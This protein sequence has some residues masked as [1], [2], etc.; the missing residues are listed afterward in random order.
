M[1]GIITKAALIYCLRRPRFYNILAST[2]HVIFL[3]TPHHGFGDGEFQAIFGQAPTSEAA[4]R[5]RVW[6][7]SLIELSSTFGNISSQSRI[8]FTTAQSTEPSATPEG[9]IIPVLRHGLT[10]LDATS[11]ETVLHPFEASHLSICKF[12]TKED[13][14][15]ALL[16][17]EILAHIKLYQLGLT[18]TSSGVA[19]QP[20]PPTEV[21]LLGNLTRTA[22]DIKR[23]LQRVD[24]TL[25]SRELRYNHEEI[26]RQRDQKKSELAALL[27]WLWPIPEAERSS[28]AMWEQALEEHANAIDNTCEWL[29]HQPS[30][31]AWAASGLSQMAF[32]HGIPASGKSTLLA[33]LIAQTQRTV[34]PLAYWFCDSQSHST[35]MAIRAMSYQLLRQADDDTAINLL[36]P[37]KNKLAGGIG[38]AS[39]AAEILKQ[40]L[41]SMPS[42][43]LV[44]DALD[45]AEAATAEKNHPQL[46]LE[47]L[48]SVVRDIPL[49]VKMFCSSRNIP[50]ILNAMESMGSAI[51]DLNLTDDLIQDD[52]D[53]V[54]AHHV[55][56]SG[57]G[58]RLKTDTV[59]DF[60]MHRLREASRGVFL[61]AIIMIEDLC[62]K[63]RVRDI[64]EFF[65][66]FP[67]KSKI[68]D[69]YLS[70]VGRVD[71]TRLGI[72]ESDEGDV[73]GFCMAQKLLT[74]LLWSRSPLTLEQLQEAL[75][76]DGA[77]F[78]DLEGDI[79]LALGCLVKSESGTI[80]ISHPSIRRFL[81]HSKVFRES[82]WYE[83]LIQPDP[84]HYL[85]TASLDYMIQCRISIAQTIPYL[86]SRDSSALYAQHPFLAYASVSWLFHWQEAESGEGFARAMWTLIHEDNCKNFLRWQVATAYFLSG[87][88]FYSLVCILQSLLIRRRDFTEKGTPAWSQLVE[89]ELCL[90]R[91]KQF[92]LVWGSTIDR[93]PMDVMSVSQLMENPN[94]PIGETPV[95]RTLLLSE[96]SCSEEKPRPLLDRQRVDY[97][98]DRFILSPTDMFLWRSLMPC[99]SHY[100]RTGA[101]LDTEC[102]QIIELA[103]R[104]LFHQFS[105][106]DYRRGLEKA[107]AGTLMASCVLAPGWKYIAIA[108]P[109]FCKD[110]SL[111]IRIKTYVF[112]LLAAPE[113][114]KAAKFMHVPWTKPSMGDDP[115]L[116]DITDSNVFRNSRAVVAFT[117]DGEG[118]WTPG[119]LYDLRSGNRTIPPSLFRDTSMSELTISVRGTH[120]A[121]IRGADKLEFHELEAD[122]C[123][124]LTSA[125]G[126]TH[127]M[128]ISALGNFVLFL[129]KPPSGAPLPDKVTPSLVSKFPDLDCEICLLDR[130]GQRTTLWQYLSVATPDPDAEELKTAPSLEFFYNNGGLQAFS[131]DDMTLVLY[132]PTF[133][134]RQLLQFDLQ[135]KEIA[136]S[137]T[138]LDFLYLVDGADLVSIGFSPTAERQ[139][140]LLDCVG[141]MR[142]MDITAKMTTGEPGTLTVAT[143]KKQVH[144]SVVLG[145][146]GVSETPILCRGSTLVTEMDWAD[147]PLAT[148]KSSDPADMFP[149]TASSRSLAWNLESLQEAPRHGID[150]SFIRYLLRI[151]SRN[152]VVAD[153]APVVRNLQLRRR[154]K[155]R[156]AGNWASIA[157]AAQ[158][159]IQ[160]TIDGC[161]EYYQDIEIAAPKEQRRSLR[162]VSTLVTFDEAATMGFFQSVIYN[163]VLPMPGQPMWRM[164]MI[165]NIRWLDTPKSRKTGAWH[166]AWV[167]TVYHESMACVY[168]QETKML[169][170]SVSLLFDVRARRNRF[171]MC[172]RLC[173]CAL[174]EQTYERRFEQKDGRGTYFNSEVYALRQ[175]CVTGLK[176]SVSGRYLYGIAE[177]GN[178]TTAFM[179]DI[180][181]GYIVRKIPMTNLNCRH[182]AF[183]MPEGKLQSK[184]LVQLVGMEPVAP[185]QITLPFESK[186]GLG[187]RELAIGPRCLDEYEQA[188]LVPCQAKDGDEV[189]HIFIA[190][191]QNYLREN[192]V[193]GRDT[194]QGVVVLSRREEH[195]AKWQE[196]R[197]DRAEDVEEPDDEDEPSLKTELRQGY[198]D[199]CESWEKWLERRKSHDNE[200]GAAGQGEME[201]DGGRQ[202]AGPPGHTSMCQEEAISLSLDVDGSITNGMASL[203]ADDLVLLHIPG[204]WPLG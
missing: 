8:H 154:R 81:L 195:V 104:N 78:V 176:F 9:A 185:V 50:S 198:K 153:P 47:I 146:H 131:N 54:I 71:G 161:E 79:K 69:Y 125:T 67:K 121:G 90:R 112:Y 177:G 18:S 38:L 199:L 143:G 173:L 133:P 37:W 49:G 192:G 43:T 106:P 73:Q 103:V 19:Q 82:K 32:L 102:P 138:Q 70:L 56:K 57:L 27:D 203:E 128:S 129:A 166:T 158:R 163:P 98:Y 126:A 179:F 45:E 91:L 93:Y 46:F 55:K 134:E 77:E 149:D 100:C 144:M 64:Y 3:D 142:T 96:T 28:P 25:Q 5:F 151:Q 114:D 44:V 180:L 145:S 124:F 16:R 113:D 137:V 36:K 86:T 123:K 160:D 63:P 157:D 48:H 101:P 88:N 87:E 120:V 194:D 76:Y 119:G 99:F 118:L 140:C 150:L 34:T 204:G 24:E 31:T 22:S 156:Q 201:A 35:V 136:Q 21:Q 202:D 188:T 187:I 183:T 105:Q 42:S 58:T 23:S 167:G 116:A 162:R 190:S 170:Y 175:E 122:R 95:Q 33:H 196:L 189:R 39:N 111:P 147:L 165:M 184:E 85:A 172:T 115:C 66:K 110:K 168:H 62:T 4:D 135:R 15:Y 181:R 171:F 164:S 178:G 107:N 89:A 94:S 26:N 159:S 17:D 10:Q 127:I 132:V 108:W 1:G 141:N 41:L 68:D 92:V 182:M 80:Q 2:H 84:H 83:R 193:V 197:S 65:D 60:V 191:G 139:L 75:C 148:I 117:E 51:I 174:S 7:S 186:D 11:H 14:N 29:F 6:S 155:Y 74:W 12:A 152:L 20:V 109:R 59:R 61:L 30:F 53:K 40:V 52:V 13:Y 97:F 130:Y 169:A 72:N 200:K